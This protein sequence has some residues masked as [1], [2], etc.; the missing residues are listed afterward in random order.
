VAVCAAAGNPAG[1]NVIRRIRR[2]GAFGTVQIETEKIHVDIVCQ[3]LVSIQATF[4]QA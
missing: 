1:E 3:K 4:A 2:R